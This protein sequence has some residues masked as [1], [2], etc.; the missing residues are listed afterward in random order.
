MTQMNIPYRFSEA[1]GAIEVPQ[2]KFTNCVCA[3]HNKVC[4]KA[5]GRFRTTR[6]GKVWYQPVQ[7]TVN[8]QRALEGELSRTIETIGP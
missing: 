3:W 8:Y 1:S 5:A 4:P 7:R 2:I 6:S